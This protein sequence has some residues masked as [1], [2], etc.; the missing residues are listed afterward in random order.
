MRPSEKVPALVKELT[1]LEG[2]SD[3]PVLIVTGA[4]D[5]FSAP[6]AEALELEGVA[7]FVYHCPGGEP[8]TA[9]AEAGAYTR[10]LHSST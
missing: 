2:C 3:Q 6:L 7:S 1:A 5:R 8:T 10:S 9:T 4:S